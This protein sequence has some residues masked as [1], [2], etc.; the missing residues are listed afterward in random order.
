[1]SSSAAEQSLTRL[2]RAPLVQTPY[3]HMYVRNVFPA[4][5]YAEMLRNL[6]DDDAYGSRAYPHRRLLEP[7]TL[8]GFWADLCA[9]M[10]SGE[11]VAALYNRFSMVRDERFGPLDLRVGFDIRLVRDDPEYHLSPH[12]DV[13]NKFLS[14]LF[15][16]PSDDRM[17]EFGTTIFQHRDPEFSH[18]GLSWLKDMDDFSPVWTAPFMPNT[19]FAF[20]RTDKSFHGVLSSD[21]GMVR[22]ALLLNIFATPVEQELTI[23]EA[24]E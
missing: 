5:F 18:D 8:G 4:D 20:A 7:A 24:A 6:P 13:P 9:W 21:C 23:E 14:F 15:Y 22:N 17:R 16:L 19:C 12:T 11:Y 3:R 1:M 10:G 2:L